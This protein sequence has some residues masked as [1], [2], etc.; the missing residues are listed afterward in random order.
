M[1]HGDDGVGLEVDDEV[2]AAAKDA[3]GGLAGED[4]AAVGHAEGLGLEGVPGAAAG[5]GLVGE[6]GDGVDGLAADDG[7]RLM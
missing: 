6:V 4:V 1:E 5:H 2:D 3:E 7:G